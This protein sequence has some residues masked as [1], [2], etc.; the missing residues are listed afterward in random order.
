MRNVASVP[1][2]KVFVFCL[3]FFLVPLHAGA[4]EDQGL[5][6]DFLRDFF[7]EAKQDEIVYIVKHNFMLYVVDRDLNVRF[8]TGVAIGKNPDHAAKLHSNDNRTPEGLYKITEA[9]YQDLP[10]DIWPYEKLQRMNRVYWYAKYGFTKWG[11]PDQDLGD[12]AYGYG[13]FRLNYPNQADK[14]R[15]MRALHRDEIPLNKDG[16]FHGWGSGIGIHGTNDPDSIGHAASTG[17]IRVENGALKRIREYLS[18]GRYVY[19][20]H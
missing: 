14:D 1:I 10:H 16:S 17:C 2:I 12:Q 5:D 11:H 20:A 13:F 9:L 18:K 4:L 6:S 19:I 7:S 3:F 15:Y 8:S